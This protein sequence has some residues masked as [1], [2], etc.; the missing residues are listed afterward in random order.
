MNGGDLLANTIKL[1]TSLITHKILRREAIIQDFRE[2]TI[3]DH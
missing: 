2:K 1:D 3:T